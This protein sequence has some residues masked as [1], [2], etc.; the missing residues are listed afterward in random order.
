MAPIFNKNKQN[1]TEEECV[2]SFGDICFVR[3]ERNSSR[4]LQASGSSQHIYSCCSANE[5]LIEAGAPTECLIPRCS[6]CDLFENDKKIRKP[7]MNKTQFSPGVGKK[8]MCDWL[9]RRQQRNYVVE[10]ISR[11]PPNADSTNTSQTIIL[12]PSLPETKKKRKRRKKSDDTVT[13]LKKKLTG[14]V[15]HAKAKNLV[16][17]DKYNCLY[18]EN[19]E[20]NVRIKKLSRK[21][22]CLEEKD[23]KKLRT[24]DTTL[25]MGIEENILEHFKGKKK[26]NEYIAK[27]VSDVILRP[28]F[29][30]GKCNDF[31]VKNKS[32]Q[33]PDSCTNKKMSLC[34]LIEK[35][36]LSGIF[37]PG[38]HSRTKAS[39]VFNE[40][41]TNNFLNGA[42]DKIAKQEFEKDFIDQCPYN[43]PEPVLRVMDISGGKVNQSCVNELR[44]VEQLGKYEKSKYL[45]STNKLKI[46][47]EQIH[48]KMDKICPYY[49]IDNRDGV[50]GIEFDYSLLL[51]YILKLF[52]LDRIAKKYGKVSI[53]ITLDG[54][55]LSRNI[56]HVT[57]GIKI[58]DPRAINPLTGIPIGLEGVQSRDYCF[59]FK[60]L[61][62]K[63][64]KA[65]YQTHF[66]PFFAWAR[67]LHE[68]GLDEFKP[69]KV[70]SPQDISSFWKCIGRGGACKRDEDFCHCCP[71]KSRDLIK[72]NLFKCVDCIR[73]CNRE[74]YHHQ[75]G[76]EKY[77]E[78]VKEDLQGLV[79]THSHLFDDENVA[80]MTLKL[81]PN[82]I[83]ANKDINNIDFDP[84]TEDELREFSQK[85]NENLR[86]LKLP[87]RGNLA[88]RKS[89]LRKHLEA[90]SRKDSLTKI[91]N[92]Y[93]IQNSM[94]LMEQAIPC[95][96]HME[97]RIGEKMLKLLLIEGYN[98]RDSDAQKQAEM[99]KN[100]Q[101][102]VN[103]SI[104]GTQRRKANWLINLTKQKEI[105]DQPMT[106]NH[107]RKVINDF[108][109]LLD[110][111]ISDLERRTQWVECIQQ[112]RDLIEMARK[113]EDFSDEEI[114]T[115]QQMC[116]T[117][118]I[119]WV[120][121]HKEAGV[122]NYIHMIGAG[123][124]S[125]Y[126]KK[127]RNLYRYSQ[128]G[129]EAL[130]S[131]IKTI[132]FRRTQR[133]GNK[134][135]GDFNSKVEPIAKWVQRTIYWKMGLDS[136]DN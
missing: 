59:P 20:L 123:H 54:A 84:Q 107:T 40:L 68:K 79:D 92:N 29:L 106:N 64:T 83:F 55:D 112:W 6:S 101:R 118:F 115:F 90:L 30:D 45:V 3:T 13:Q 14:E 5:V 103:T 39:H 15:S 111:C 10:N 82:D 23:R 27:Q 67:E 113:R 91:L 2:Y 8:Y 80:K 131:Q 36:Y 63:D 119:D 51:K 98:E 17:E 56:Q 117:F 77:L 44:N 124:L 104:L 76:D 50:D 61:L 4:S 78:D 60:I 129:W 41:W 100:V 102:I 66:K 48:D 31:L 135:G 19:L 109:L 33:N 120:K 26:T 130:N 87:R 86:L 53:G 95:V 71:L 88:V 49:M 134:G 99:I 47:Q 136:E 43:Q 121:L 1:Y 70:A 7:L 116:D 65:L 73:R 125:Y 85:V 58:L 93:N 108:E 57:C 25:Q 127:W 22:S 9:L 133:G 122:G 96:L 34:D 16:L 114:E 28:S 72:P 24:L 62:A 18:N 110:A 37:K 128:Q 12:S 97:N 81:S 11:T 89:L 74:C 42:L 132:Y 126:L 105:A 21:I 52:K 32:S 69:F 46:L 38:I 35:E 94:I 75:V